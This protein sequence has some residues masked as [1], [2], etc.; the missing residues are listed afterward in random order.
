ML[1]NFRF[2]DDERWSQS[3][4]QRRWVGLINNRLISVVLWPPDSNS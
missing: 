1:V 3:P 2:S 4:N